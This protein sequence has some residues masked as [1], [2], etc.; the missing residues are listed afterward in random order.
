MKQEKHN[1]KGIAIAL[2]TALSLNFSVKP[3]A[4]KVVQKFSG[5]VSAQTPEAVPNET[6]ER[7]VKCRY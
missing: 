7:T 4:R 6:K 2:A 1:G 5:E 3:L